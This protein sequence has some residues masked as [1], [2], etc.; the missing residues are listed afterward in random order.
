MPSQYSGLFSKGALGILLSGAFVLSGA[1]CS[2]T[3]Q[4]VQDYALARAALEACK[5]VEA[6]RY[7]QGYYHRGLEAY[8]RAEVLYRER[9][10]QE[11][12]E[13]FVRA[14]LDFEKAENSAQVQ[15]K[16]SGE[17]L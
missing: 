14:R 2:T 10:Y 17:V 1:G 13:L 15:R 11:A 4:P 6:A 3:P 12:R 5:A 7:S 9:E 16:K 8:S